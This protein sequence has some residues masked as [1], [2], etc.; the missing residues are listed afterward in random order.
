MDTLIQS[1]SVKTTMQLFK[2]MHRHLE[3]QPVFNEQLTEKMAGYTRATLEA[4]NCDEGAYIIEERSNA[5]SWQN[6]KGK[7]TL[8]AEIDAY[9]PIVMKAE[10]LSAAF[11]IIRKQQSDKENYQS[12]V[13]NLTAY[14]D[15]FSGQ[16][17]SHSALTVKCFQ[18]DELKDNSELRENIL[19]TL[20]PFAAESV[21]ALLAWRNK[22]IEA[23]SKDNKVLVEKMYAHAPAL[24]EQKKYLAAI[25][26]LKLRTHHLANDDEAIENLSGDVTPYIQQAFEAKDYKTGMKLSKIQQHILLLSNRE[27]PVRSNSILDLAPYNAQAIVEKDYE[28]AMNLFEYRNKSLRYHFAHEA[29]TK[30]IGDELIPF[31]PTLLSENKQAI[32]H[33]CQQLEME[34][35]LPSLASE[36]ETAIMK[37]QEIIPYAKELFAA[38]KIDQ[39]LDVAEFIYTFLP[40]NSDQEYADEFAAYCEKEKAEFMKEYIGTEEEG[41]MNWHYDQE[42]TRPGDL[43]PE[44]GLARNSLLRKSFLAEIYPIAGQLAKD[45]NK[46]EASRIYRWMWRHLIPE[47]QDQLEPVIKKVKPNL[48]YNDLQY[49]LL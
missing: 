40:Q 47:E 49:S 35:R 36:N 46:P 13:E 15:I 41:Y 5:I 8:T 30:M 48:T 17:K 2:F 19:A 4:G 31:L 44:N 18:Y 42:H 22:H 39:G 20:P 24:V 21:P 3:Y 28:T 32:S 33:F 45:G 11:R 38:K 23:D 43:E 25:K 26:L 29:Q 37:L 14:A 34:D 16:G 1:E 7:E 27:S 12:R 9:V 10:N 6:N